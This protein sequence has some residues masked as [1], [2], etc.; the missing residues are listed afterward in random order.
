MKTLGLLIII[1]NLA[2]HAYCRKETDDRSSSYVL[3]KQYFNNKDFMS[4]YKYLLMYKYSNYDKLV[5]PENSG[6]LDTLNK[7]NRN[8]LVAG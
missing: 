2:I 7:P 8:R 5:K 4:A 1:A 3:A 6:A